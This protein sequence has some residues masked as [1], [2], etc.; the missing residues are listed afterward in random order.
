MFQ[1]G[2]ELSFSG[3]KKHQIHFLVKLWLLSSKVPRRQPDQSTRLTLSEFFGEVIQPVFFFG[4]SGV[5]PIKKICWKI[6]GKIDEI[7]A[8]S[9][10][11]GAFMWKGPLPSRVATSILLARTARCVVEL[12]EDAHIFRIIRPQPL[13]TVTCLGICVDFS[14][15]VME[16]SC[17]A[18]PLGDKISKSLQ[19]LCGAHVTLNYAQLLAFPCNN[20]DK[21]D[22]FPSGL[23]LFYSF[24]LFSKA[25]FMIS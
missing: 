16:L 18:V 3:N 19:S 15:C 2:V 14:N 7:C 4:R 23:R 22:A 20:K 8:F 25:N 17:P 12:P 9:H 21:E 5:V 10:L 13:T 24:G 6:H 11:E 1:R